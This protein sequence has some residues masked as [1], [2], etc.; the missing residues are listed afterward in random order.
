MSDSFASRLSDLRKQLQLSQKEASQALGISQALL[1]HYENGIRECGLDFIVKAADFY[2]VT[3]DYLLCKSSSKY[4]F[5]DM[6]NCE[7]RLPDDSILT[8]I[9]VYR[10]AAALREV[11]GNTNDYFFR[12]TLVLYSICIYRVLLFGV[13]RG[14]IPA[15][16]INIESAAEFEQYL[17]AVDSLL[18]RMLDVSARKA[19]LRYDYEA[20][21][22]E[23]LKTIIDSAHEAFA[24]R[25]DFLSKI[26]S[27]RMSENTKDVK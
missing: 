25:A 16:W 9:T 20:D 26:V 2:G 17:N 27:E 8:T 15:N 3:C 1:S 12:Q 4:G 22:P 7:I 18:L 11:L 23:S 21:I 14:K 6:L 5:T 13:S 19:I 10:A 24:E